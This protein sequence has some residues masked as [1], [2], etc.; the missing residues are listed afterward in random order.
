MLEVTTIKSI[1]LLACLAFL[2]SGCLTL[3]EVH[4]GP[5]TTE[6]KK[7][8]RPKKKDLVA[9]RIRF[10]KSVCDA[11]LEAGRL[12][13]NLTL[14]EM[15]MV[16]GE[17]HPALKKASKGFWSCVIRENLLPFQSLIYRA[18]RDRDYD[19]AELVRK[20]WLEWLKKIEYAEPKIAKARIKKL[21][22]FEIPKGN[23]EGVEILKVSI[24]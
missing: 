7:K 17:K 10:H 5:G 11:I 13:G 12:R 4:Y 21:E 23:C 3:H 24:D 6:V 14:S 2:C 16:A 18:L 19:R 15:K 8:V 9:Q 1:V 20:T 22:T